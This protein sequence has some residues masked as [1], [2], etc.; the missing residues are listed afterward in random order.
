[1]KLSLLGG[2]PLIVVIFVYKTYL[3][4]K[5]T[6]EEIASDRL[7]ILNLKG[8]FKNLVR[9]A[10]QEEN[11]QSESPDNKSDAHDSQGE[12][13]N[14][15]E[16]HNRRESPSPILEQTLKSGTKEPIPSILKTSTGGMLSAGNEELLSSGETNKLSRT[17]KQSRRVSIVP[18]DV[19]Q[20]NT[21]QQ[22]ELV[23]FEQLI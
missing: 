17:M 20:L 18:Y 21:S 12:I 3:K 14:L 16:S 22:I 15:D 13:H 7:T 4:K 9:E 23:E 1:M 11:D 19:N 8:F 6:E 10:Q 2:I 5:T